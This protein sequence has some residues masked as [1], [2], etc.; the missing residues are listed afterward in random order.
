MEVDSL[1]TLTRLAVFCL[2]FFEHIDYILVL[3]IVIHKSILLGLV[4]C[5]KLYLYVLTCQRIPFYHVYWLL[6][7]VS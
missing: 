2:C 4:I 6:S 5:K 7:N 1:A 3:Y